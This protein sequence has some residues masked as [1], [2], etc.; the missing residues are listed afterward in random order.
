MM[1][2]FSTRRRALLFTALVYAR[3][4][5]DDAYGTGIAFS[6]GMHKI[7][8]CSNNRL[9][10][11]SLYG[12]L[13]DERYEVETAELPAVAVQMVL[14]KEYDAM[15]IDSEPFGLSVDDAIKIIKSL[16]P[17]LPVVFI[18][19]EGLAIDALSIV[20]PVNLQR[21]KEVVRNLDDISKVEYTRRS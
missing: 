17:D 7:L 14:R 10:V 8:L 1:G 4:F 19:Y 20:P 13:R 5:G 21:F 2:Y 9:L 12:I 3:Y 18:G 15:I 6:A 16:R 11:K